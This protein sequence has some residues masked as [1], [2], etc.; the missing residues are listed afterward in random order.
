MARKMAE[1]NK[2]RRN[3]IM[4]P[5]YKTDTLRISVTSNITA[6]VYCIFTDPKWWILPSVRVTVDNDQYM[7]YCSVVNYCKT[8]DKY[9]R[10]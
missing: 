5:K 7:I 10:K 1:Y 9:S 2:S 8:K 6:K 3:K 4:I